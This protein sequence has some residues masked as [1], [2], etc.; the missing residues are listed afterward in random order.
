MRWKKQRIT[1]I[2]SEKQPAFLKTEF[3]VSIRIQSG[4]QTFNAQQAT[5]NMQ[6]MRVLA[7]AHCRDGNDDDGFARKSRL[8]RWRHSV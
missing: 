6:P 5:P 2:N 4:W 1:V 7:H 3:Y 8:A